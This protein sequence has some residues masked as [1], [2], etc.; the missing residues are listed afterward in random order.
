MTLGTIIQ[1]TLKCALPCAIEWAYTSTKLRAGEFGGGCYIITDSPIEGG[2]NAR[3]ARQ[4]LENSP[5][6]LCY[7]RERKG[8]AEHHPLSG[9]RWSLDIN[10]DPTAVA[11]LA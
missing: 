7:D 11:R 6:S 3:L 8:G 4:E 10:N 5:A 1:K 9:A 2:S